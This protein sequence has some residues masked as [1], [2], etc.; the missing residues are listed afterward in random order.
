VDHTYDRRP[1]TAT[2]REFQEMAEIYLKKLGYSPKQVRSWTR[3]MA[4]AIEKA[5]KSSR[6]TREVEYHIGL[7]EEGEERLR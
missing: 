6:E 7:E 1:K 5:L 2:D 3:N 4:Q